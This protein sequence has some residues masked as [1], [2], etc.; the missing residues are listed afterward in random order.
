MRIILILLITFTCLNS[1]AQKSIYGRVVDKETQT[2]LK[3]AHIIV[4]GGVKGTVTDDSGY[5][6]FPEEYKNSIARISYTGYKFLDI[7]LSIKKQPLVEL[8]KELILYPQMNIGLGEYTGPDKYSEPK[9]NNKENEAIV[10]QDFT[11]VEEPASFFG[12]LDNLY[13]FLAVN[14]Q[15]PKTVL[16]KKLSGY[17]YIKFTTLPNGSISAIEFLN[18]EIPSEIKD[19]FNRVFSLMPNWK[20]ATQSGQNVEQGFVINIKYSAK[21]YTSKP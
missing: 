1:I 9:A 12:G 20:P 18:D 16:E 11:V 2:P 7:K 19:E 21:N 8:E 4:I 5:F 6:E 3:G 13:A 14:F 10:D 15:Y 17:A